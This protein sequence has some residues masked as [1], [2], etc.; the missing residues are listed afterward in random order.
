MLNLYLNVSWNWYRTDIS[1]VILPFSAP[2]PVICIFNF[3]S[4]SLRSFKSIGYSLKIWVWD[5]DN[6]FPM[7]CISFFVGIENMVTEYTKSTS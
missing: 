3:Y 6:F 2:Y 4:K 7:L 5:I 1:R